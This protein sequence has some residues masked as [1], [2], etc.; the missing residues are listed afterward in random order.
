M[1]ESLSAQNYCFLFDCIQI[2]VMQFL[3]AQEK[4]IDGSNILDKRPTGLSH[5]HLPYPVYSNNL[6]LHIDIHQQNARFVNV[7]PSSSQMLFE[8]SK[9]VFKCSLFSNLNCY[10]FKF[11]FQTSAR[12]HTPCTFAIVK[13]SI[14]IVI[15]YS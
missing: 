13:F 3:Y 12:K 6:V 7:I 2:K 1:V 5:T 8:L 14:C 15:G 4:H 10:L 11:L 9:T